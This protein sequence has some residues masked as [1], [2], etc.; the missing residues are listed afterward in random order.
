MENY[1]QNQERISTDLPTKNQVS[2]RTGIVA[3]ALIQASVVASKNDNIEK[4]IRMIKEAAAAGA[5]IICLQE[6]F[7]TQYFAAQQDPKWFALAEPVPGPTTELMQEI[8]AAHQV[9]LIVPLPEVEM[10]G[11]YYNTSVVIDADGTI[12]GKYRKV[13]VPHLEC[14]WEKYYFK[15]GNLGYPV[16]N[17]KYAKIGVFIDFDRHYP[18][19]PRILALKGAQILY[20]PCTTIM[21]L[22]RYIWFIVQRS[23]AVINGVFVGT[24]NRVGKEP[25][26]PGAYYG[27]SYFCGPN[28]EILAQGSQDKDEIVLAQLNLTH[29]EKER[30]RWNFFRDRQPDTYSELISL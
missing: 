30:N 23:H 11:I 4:N 28:G 5:Q 9:V 1:N 16:F 15:T 20:N 19:V 3:S 13:H 29:I 27:T 21:D 8:A 12:L 10:P 26:S 24:S 14:F 22:S 25:Y 18:E 7:Y 2:D 6:M 17:T